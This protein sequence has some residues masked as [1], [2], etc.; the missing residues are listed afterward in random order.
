MRAAVTEEL[1]EMRQQHRN[2]Q[3]FGFLLNLNLWISFELPCLVSVTTVRRRKM[4]AMK[5][6]TR[7]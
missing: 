5:M 7:G 1:R 3:K 4:V 2:N 6:Q